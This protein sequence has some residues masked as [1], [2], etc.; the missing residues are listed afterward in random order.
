MLS[1]H[2]KSGGTLDTKQ[3][4]THVNIQYKMSQGVMKCLRKTWSILKIEKCVKGKN[5]VEFEDTPSVKIKTTLEIKKTGSLEAISFRRTYE[6]VK[7]RQHFN[8]ITK[9]KIS[10]F[11]KK[12]LEGKNRFF[13]AFLTL[14]VLM[15]S[16]KNIKLT[17]Y[18]FIIIEHYL[19]TPV[20]W[21]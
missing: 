5:K 11:E 12:L 8:K 3:G 17:Y 7:W 4:S 2:K 20:T 6:C 18:S 13:L 19:K 1:V 10:N 9:I 21:I 15:G 16:L 14:R